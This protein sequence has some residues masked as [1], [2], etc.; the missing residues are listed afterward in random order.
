MVDAASGAVTPLTTTNAAFP[1]FSMGGIFP[2]LQGAVTPAFSPDGKYVAYCDQ[3]KPSGQ[4]EVFRIRADG[5]G[6]P[7]RLTSSKKGAEQHVTLGWQ[8]LPRR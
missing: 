2:T 7:T 1:P 3:T 6:R 8:P 5:K 4:Y